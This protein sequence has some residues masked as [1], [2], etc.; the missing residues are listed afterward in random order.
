MK[1]CHKQEPDKTVETVSEVSLLPSNTSSDIQDI[2]VTECDEDF[3]VQARIWSLFIR[4][5]NNFI[6]DDMMVS[7]ASCDVTQFA[8]SGVDEEA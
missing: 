5:A 1:L 8:S 6:C 4:Q 2:E 3:E 7:A